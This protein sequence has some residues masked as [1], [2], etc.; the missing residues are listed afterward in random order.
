M[1]SYGVAIN[2]KGK[3]TYIKD[4]VTGVIITYN[5][6]KNIFGIMFKEIGRAHV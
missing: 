3:C 2:N 1:I 6:N 4:G 5:K